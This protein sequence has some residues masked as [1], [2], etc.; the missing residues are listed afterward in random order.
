MLHT[1]F[2]DHLTSGSGGEY[3]QR[4]LPYMGGQPSWPYRLNHLYKLSYLLLKKAPHKIWLSLA[5]QLQKRRR[6]KLGTDDDGGRTMGILL[7]HL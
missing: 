4:F 6:L 7:A 1:E 3:F 5:K 2:Q